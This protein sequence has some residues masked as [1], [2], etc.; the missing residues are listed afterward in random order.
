MVGRRR[1]RE[2]AEGN[3]RA[4]ELPFLFSDNML[5]YPSLCWAWEE[6]LTVLRGQGRTSIRELLDL[7]GSCLFH[8]AR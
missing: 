2:D 3:G 8:R 5:G 6:M 1:G 7:R 4:V